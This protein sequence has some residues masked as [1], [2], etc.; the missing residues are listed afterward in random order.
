MHKPQQST[1]GLDTPV[2]AELASF[3]AVAEALSFTR[4]GQRLER[5]ATVLSR[6]VSALEAR[7]GVRLVQRTTRRVALTE[8]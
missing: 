4:A 2:F 6:R 8:A 5:D 7:L 1:T 3:V